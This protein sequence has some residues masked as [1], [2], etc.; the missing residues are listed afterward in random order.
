MFLKGAVEAPR[1]RPFH[2]PAKNPSAVQ[3]EL[4]GETVQPGARRFLQVHEF[5]AAENRRERKLAFAAQRLRIDHEPWL[6]SGS[7]HVLPMKALV[8]EN[9]FTLGR[10][11]RL[12]VLES[13]VDQHSFAGTPRSFPGLRQVERPLPRCIPPFSLPRIRCG[14]RPKQQVRK[15]RVA[16]V[17]EAVASTPEAGNL[18]L[19]NLYFDR[20]RLRF[21][22]NPGDRIP[23]IPDDA[24][25]NRRRPLPHPKPRADGA[26]S[27]A[28][29][30]A[31]DGVV[32]RGTGIE[33]R[34]I[35]SHVSPHANGNASAGRD[36]GSMSRQGKD[37]FERLL[38][39]LYQAVLDDSHWP[40][41]SALIDE[42]CGSKGNILVSGDG[43][44]GNDVD[45]YFARCC[46]R[47]ER[48]E[49]FE[50]EY[51]RVY[52]HLDERG[53]RLRRLPDSRIVNIGELYTDQEKRTS[54]A[55]NEMLALSDTRN[56]LHA[57]LD[58]P[59]GS[60]IIWTAADPVDDT[61]WSPSRVETVARLLPHIRQFVRVRLALENS[62]ALGAT[63]TE[64]LETTRCAIIQLDRRGR[65]VGVNDRARQMLRT[66]KGLADTRGFLHARNPGEDAKLQSLFAR[67]LPRFG[68]PGVS[69]SMIV[70]GSVDSPPHSVLHMNPAGTGGV[71]RGASRVAAIVLVVEPE[72]Q[73]SADP[74]LVGDA[75]GLTRAESRV[76]V[77]LAEGYTPRDIA[78]ATGRS[79]GTVRWHLKQIFVKNRISR[80]AEL[81]QLVR[82]V[83]VIGS[84][85]R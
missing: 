47:G 17:P 56:C 19:I 32:E 16:V 45:I 28:S 20:I 21:R 59:D 58:G 68:G 33:N 41:A 78:E 55:Y 11:Q 48:R 42:V 60:R 7:K 4:A 84:D 22:S 35:G 13:G 73:A 51:F 24:G 8:D 15:D 29:C 80:Q 71:E 31:A 14:A 49:D 69:G 5:N 81:V 25:S 67:A 9:L 23:E 79:I 61:G 3:P 1:P 36:A 65:I 26:D 30:K 76:A 27:R 64:L 43:G 77:M 74:E 40:V 44:L 46:Y 6:A 39:S 57:R 50:S 2:G 53:P 70:T 10:R 12:E 34:L 37:L 63:L 82:S 85:R 66:G 83:S 18:S 54:V 75:L 52:H 62:R 38:S 72:K